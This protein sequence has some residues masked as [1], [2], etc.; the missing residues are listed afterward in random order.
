[1][2]KLTDKEKIV[3]YGLVKYPEL[4]DIE[5]AQKIKIKRPTITAIRNR[6]EKQ[7]IYTTK[8]IPDISC[9]GCEIINITHTE[10]NPVTPYKTRKTSAENPNT[11]LEIQTDNQKL[12]ISCE[13]NYT[14]TIS[15]IEE[16]IRFNDKHG[17]ANKKQITN[18]IFPI[19]LSTLLMNFEFGPLIRKTLSIEEKKE[20]KTH[21]H[22]G[23]KPTRLNETEKTIL[24]ALVKYP[25]LR[26]KEIAEK[27]DYT[28]Q[29]VNNIH[30]KLKKEKLVKTIRVPNIKKL[31][32]ELIV[33]TNVFMKPVAKI[34]TR[35]K[36]AD[37][38]IEEG[39]QVF[40]ISN[41][42]ESAMLSVSKNY[43]KVR[44]T[45]RKLFSYYKQNDF[46]EKRPEVKIIPINDVKHYRYDYTKLTKNIL[47]I[48]KEI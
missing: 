19:K 15:K 17:Y 48:K 22:E 11:F 25:E 44:K 9:L 30:R 12:T 6:L 20:G 32:L 28:R 34:E 40:I 43:T 46:L 31:G 39:S 7:R 10:Y 45:Y 42:L 38:V 5:L 14:Q 47:D 24:Y 16:D 4:N 35:F 13:K 21:G 36:A 37:T 29:T 1:M 8:K 18:T 3:L 27:T 23:I 26:E 41:L 33:F 2:A